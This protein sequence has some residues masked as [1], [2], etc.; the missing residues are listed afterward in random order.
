MCNA[1]SP[2]MVSSNKH[3]LWS[4]AILAEGVRLRG[5]DSSITPQASGAETCWFATGFHSSA[6]RS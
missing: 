5:V 3:Q 6:D 1:S 4:Q 2:G